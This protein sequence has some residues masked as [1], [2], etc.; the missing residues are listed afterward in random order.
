MAQNCADKIYKPMVNPYLAVMVGV[1]AVSFS[2]LF[3]KLST[4]PSII[5]ATYRL[6]FT[7]LILAPYS[8]A[9]K[10]KDILNLSRRQVVLAALSG[11][12]LALHFVTWFTSLKYTS[13]ASSVVIV[14][15]QP[16]FVVLG[17]YLFFGEKIS[18]KSMIGGVLAF[19]G[20]TFVGA[21]DFELGTRALFGDALALL[22]AVM[23]SGYMLIG[24]SLRSEVNLPAYTFVTYGSSSLVLVLSSIL[25][26]QALAP[27][28]LKNWLLFLA[29][30]VVCTVFGHTVFNW[31]LRYVQASFVAVG[32]LGEPVGA[33]FWAFLFLAETPTAHQLI[34]GT[35]IIAG[36]FIFT[37]YQKK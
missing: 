16:I 25:A 24:R 19:A 23:V 15:T 18:A 9:V 8:V 28:T 37:K 35:L 7:F 5:I 1:L 33:I 10:S 21:A 17:S 11:I 36:I 6:V 12:F 2:S 26:G 4:A 30:A 13:V 3:V 20:S 22:A 34:G 14:T 32:V 31:A 29:L 27:Y